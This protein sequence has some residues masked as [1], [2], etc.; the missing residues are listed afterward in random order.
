MI[1]LDDPDLKNIELDNIQNP[2][3]GGMGFNERPWSWDSNFPQSLAQQNAPP[4]QLVHWTNWYGT[5]LPFGLMATRKWAVFLLGIRFVRYMFGITD[6]SM[7]VGLQEI[8][9]RLQWQ[10]KPYFSA[11]YHFFQYDISYDSCRT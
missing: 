8:H 5:E 9:C 7:A 4:W 10:W 11:G 1:I 2:L 3:G 6:S